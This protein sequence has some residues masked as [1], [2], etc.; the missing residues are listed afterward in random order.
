MLGL[1]EKV[2]GDHLGVNGIVGNNEHLG[3]AGDE[4]DPDAAK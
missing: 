4:I 2:D 3:R 1:S